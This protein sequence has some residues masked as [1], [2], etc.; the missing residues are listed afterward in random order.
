MR[1]TGIPD[2][3]WV[4]DV[5]GVRVPFF[6]VRRTLQAWRASGGRGASIV[7]ERDGERHSVADAF[8]DTGVMRPMSFWE[9]R[10]LAFRPV[11][12]DGEESACR[13]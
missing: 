4:A 10:F 3:R 8:A 6:E 9:R 12:E 1:L 2:S 5:P 13:W 7:Y 11:Q